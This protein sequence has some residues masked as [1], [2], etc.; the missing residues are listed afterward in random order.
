VAGLGGFVTVVN[1]A[2]AQN[3]TTSA[4]PWVFGG[5]AVAASADGIKLVAAPIGPYGWADG[6]PFGYPIYLSADAGMSWAPASAPTNYWISVASSADGAKLVAAASAFFG[7]GLIYT[8]SDGGGTWART[9]APSNT[10]ASV[11]SSA[12]GVRLVAAASAFFGDGLLYTSGDAGMTWAPTSAPSNTWASV[13]SSAD[14]VRLVAAGAFGGGLIY[15]SGDAGVTW[16]RTAAPSNDWTSVACSAD[17][18]KMVASAYFGPIITSTNSGTS[19]VTTS[20]PRLGW[21]S[22]A[23]SADG[24]KLW[25]A[26]DWASE[27]SILGP[28]YHSAD[29]G[30]TWTVT[31]APSAFWLRVACSADG[32][33]A[34]AAGATS[35]GGE[36]GGVISDAQAPPF[37]PSLQLSIGKSA[38]D[39]RL[40]WLVPSTSLVV[41][42]ISSLDSGDW[43]AVTNQPT[44]NFTNVHYE[45]TLPLSSTNAFYRLKAQ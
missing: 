24:T 2:L 28:I 11:A 39:V 33:V 34:I 15:T 29:S 25:A 37:A 36:L 1:L 22:T 27:T 14:G 23:S 35:G 7:D 38:S 26:A 17:G 3:W 19:W 12:D 30:V 41:Q 4:A 45:V 18:T 9:S 8:S 32:S 43:L 40:S 13:A 20:A 6:L 10:W 16:A 44:L 5:A 21:Q 42:Q 31:P